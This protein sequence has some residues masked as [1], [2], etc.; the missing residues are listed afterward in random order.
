MKECRAVL[1]RRIRLLMERK[2][3]LGKRL[4]GRNML[5]EG[6][7][8]SESRKRLWRR[9]NRLSWWRKKVL[10]RDELLK[11]VDVIEKVLLT[12]KLLQRQ[13]VFWE[14]RLERARKQLLR[15]KDVLPGD[16]EFEWFWRDLEEGRVLRRD[17][18]LK[19]VESIERILMFKLSDREKMLCEDGLK[20]VRKRLS[21]YKDR[22]S[23]DRELEEFGGDLEGMREEL[24]LRPI[25][26]DGFLK[27]GLKPF[28]VKDVTLSL[29]GIVGF[30]RGC[31]LVEK[32]KRYLR[33][34]TRVVSEL[35]DHCW[36]GL[37]FIF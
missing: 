7:L 31:N 6:T 24:E 5:F 22:L 10:G 1:N 14:N 8:L 37:R 21:W 15:Y 17:K 3:G 35:N 19:I 33:E 29:R 18:L 16:R 25:Y 23:R 2:K 13:R 26:V 11:N 20:S 30:S 28:K 34:R 9:I 36:F 4:L 12:C 32:R 27:L